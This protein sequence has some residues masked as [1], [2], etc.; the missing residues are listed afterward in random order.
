M[1]IEL[2]RLQIKNIGVPKIKLEVTIELYVLLKSPVV[3]VIQNN[4]HLYRIA[5]GKPNNA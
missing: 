1:L 2:P 4:K 3:S 5:H